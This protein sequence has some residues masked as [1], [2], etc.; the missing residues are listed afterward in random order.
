MEET[1]K[2][3]RDW[4]IE[5]L[6][7]IQ[8]QLEDMAAS[9]AGVVAQMRAAQIDALKGV[10]AEKSLLLAFDNFHAWQ[11]YAERHLRNQMF[12]IR[13]GHLGIGGMKVADAGGE[14]SRTADEKVEQLGRDLAAAKKI[15]TKK[16]KTG[17]VPKTKPG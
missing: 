6:A 7:G 9:L 13:T 1:R 3:T 15:G 17:G 4:T 11:G 16:P 2:S 12:A 10:P 5:D 14:Y 8:S